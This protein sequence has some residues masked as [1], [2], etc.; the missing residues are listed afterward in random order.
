MVESAGKWEQ[1]WHPLR[2]EWVVYSAHRNQRP[3]SG[4]SA[5]QAKERPEFDPQCYLCPGNPRVHGQRNPDYKEVFIFDND[6]PVVG[7]NAPG[8]PPDLQELHG[9]LYRRRRASG[10]A[11]VVCYD[12]RHNVSLAQIPQEQVT[13]VF[14]AWREQMRELRNHPEVQFVLIFENRGEITGVSNPHPHCQ[15]YATNFVFPIIEVEI[16]ASI[17]YEKAYRKNLFASLLQAEQEDR[18]RIIAD[19]EYACAFIPFFAR[20]AYEIMIFPKRRHATLI[21]MRD[22]EL[23]DLASVFQQ[24]IRRYDLLFNIPFPY[25]MSIMQAP[26]R[27]DDNIGYHLHIILQP[28][29]RQP[30]LQKFLAGPEIGGG[31]FMADTMPEEKAKELQNLRLSDYEKK[32]SIR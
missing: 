12:R 9:G 28:P 19:N 7:M 23:N 4:A 20:Y 27:M 26:L 24:V 1:R 3:W 5:Q 31:A 13:Q 30:G 22:E 29:L 8:I 6:L 2:R 11:R 32:N 16:E 17:E 14:I 15:I 10:L 21:T 18:V 25:V